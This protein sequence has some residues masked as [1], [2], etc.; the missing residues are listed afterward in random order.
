M[1]F[2]GEVLP[3]KLSLARGRPYAQSLPGIL[4]AFA[5]MKWSEVRRRVKSRLTGM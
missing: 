4:W 2:P 3:Q 5:A 1:A